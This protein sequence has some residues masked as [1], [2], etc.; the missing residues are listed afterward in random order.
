MSSCSHYQGCKK[1]KEMLDNKTN[2]E[3]VAVT[4]YSR[5]CERSVRPGSLTEHM[6]SVYRT[7]L[8]MRAT[9]D[10]MNSLRKL[11][12][13]DQTNVS[14]EAADPKVPRIGVKCLRNAI[15]RMNFDKMTVKKFRSRQIIL[16]GCR[17][18]TSSVL[19]C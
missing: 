8:S 5:L 10:L 14:T 12:L 13:E 4:T 16:Y 9:V 18:G 6:L 3:N 2:S 7:R 15:A 19:N 11:D 17:H 1:T